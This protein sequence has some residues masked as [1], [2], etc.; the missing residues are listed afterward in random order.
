M[1]AAGHFQSTERRTVGTL[2]GTGVALGVATAIGVVIFSLLSRVLSGTV[3]N[4]VLLILVL[5]GG[6]V[7]A[8]GPAAAVRPQTIDAVGWSAFVGVI[9]AWTFTA[10]DIIILRPVGLYSWRWDAIGGGSGWWYIPVWWMASAFL[11]WLGGWSYA[12]RA[13]RGAAV[14]L[15]NLAGLTAGVALIITGLLSLLHVVPFNAAGMALGLG[16]SVVVA[17]PISAAMNRR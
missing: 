15:S 12:A 7:A 5:L 14:Q 10:L 3:G 8:F 9:S 13:H 6:L 4:W 2:L 11:A 16:I 1:T 17:V